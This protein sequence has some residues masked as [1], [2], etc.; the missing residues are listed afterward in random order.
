MFY[1]ILDS[2]NRS[3]NFASAGHNPMILYRGRTKEVYFIKPKG[4][5]VGIDLPEDDMFAKNLALQRVS[6]DKNDML[7]IYTDGITEAMDP[8]GAQF[9]EDRLVTVIKENSH[10]TP[11][12]FVEKLNEAIAQFTRRAEQN[13][14]ITVVAIKEKM[15]VEQVEFKF[16]KK[17]LDLVERKGLSVAQACRQMNTS[18]NTYYRLKKIFNEQ[19]KA[20]LKTIQKKK[21]VALRELSLPQ[22]Q[23]VMRV[24]REKPELGPQKIVDVLWQE[25]PPVK[26]DAKF[27]SEFL[28]RKGLTD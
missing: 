4:F 3:I 26:I 18:T 1:I 20:G 9:G 27:V 6:L 13:D 16:R 17:L 7:V 22:Q 11:Q 25:T 19:G 28:K 5:P 12:E 21:R 2:R 8:E 10:F 23:A 24:V 14:D 15:K